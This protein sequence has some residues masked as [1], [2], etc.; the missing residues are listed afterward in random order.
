MIDKNQYERACQIILKAEKPGLS[1]LMRELN[2]GFNT[3]AWLL[4]QMEEA[5][6]VSKIQPSGERHILKKEE[7]S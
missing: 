1:I 4:D 6:I 3:A 7:Q 5:G 2:V